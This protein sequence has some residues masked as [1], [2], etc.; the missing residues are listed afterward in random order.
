MGD[1]Y[2]YDGLLGKLYGLGPIA[3]IGRLKGELYELERKPYGLEDKL[4]GLGPMAE[5]AE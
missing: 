4:D 5:I 1:G 3:E 2:G